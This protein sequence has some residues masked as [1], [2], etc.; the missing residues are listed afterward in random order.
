MSNLL[1][2]KTAFERITAARKSKGY[3][4]FGLKTK[5]PF[6]VMITGIRGESK[7]SDLFD[8]WITLCYFD[9][10]KKEICE[11]YPATTDPGK[12]MRTNPIFY[13]QIK[14]GVAILKPGHYPSCYELGY[15]GTG[16]W[17]HEALIQVGTLI[18]WR[19]NNRDERLDWDKNLPEHPCTACGVNIHMA[20][21]NFIA[22][23]VDSW[24]A[25]CQVIQNPK[26]FLRFMDVV[27]AS[28][29]IYGARVSYTL[30]NIT[31]L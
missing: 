27:K 7:T 6:N 2:P 4:N 8:D 17:R 16:N 29:K 24:S 23:N 14:N 20:G 28:M 18:L 10:N 26:D 19:D 5:S 11:I 22:Q 30:L 9:E 12:R 3:P 15:H 25:G 31:D 21:K 13:E 1:D